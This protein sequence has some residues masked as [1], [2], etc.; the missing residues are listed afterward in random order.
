MSAIITLSTQFTKFTDSTQHTMF[1]EITQFTEHT[2]FT[3]FAHITLSITPR[4]QN[5]ALRLRKLRSK[6]SSTLLRGCLKPGALISEPPFTN[7]KS[8]SEHQKIF[9]LIS[10]KRLSLNPLRTFTQSALKISIQVY[11]ISHQLQCLATREQPNVVAST[12]FSS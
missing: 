11:I 9:W 7:Q 2:S 10:T 3:H 1:T 6:L 8:T 12:K 4:L 5:D